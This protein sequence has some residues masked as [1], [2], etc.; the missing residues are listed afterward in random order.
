MKTAG[1]RHLLALALDGLAVALVAG[2]GCT[3]LLLLAG[4]QIL[5]WYWPLVVFA[6]TLAVMILRLRRY[7]LSRYAVAQLL[8]TRL[9]LHDRLST[10]VWFRDRSEGPGEVLQAI[11]TQASSSLQPA[12]VERSFPITFP[13]YGY[14]GVALLAAAAGLFGVRYLVLHTVDLQKPLARL[15]LAF[16][17]PEPKTTQAASR[18]SVVKE[19]LDQQLQELGLPV[20]DPQTPDGSAVQP[21]E[22]TIPGGADQ[23]SPAAGKGSTPQQQPSPDG[24]DTGE[25]SG[26]PTAGEQG[27]AAG[28]NAVDKQTPGKNQ[29]PPKDGAKP[30]QGGNNSNLMN[31]LRDALANMMNKMKMPPQEGQSAENQQDAKQG[32]GQ[33]QGN[34]GKAQAQGKGQQSQQQGEQQGEQEGEQVAGDNSRSGDKSSDKAGGEQSKSGRGRS[35]GDKSIRDA[36][37]LAAMGKLSEILGKRSQQITGEMTVE[38]S[39]GKQQLKTGWTERKA[40][41]GDTGGEANR[42]EI[43]LAYQTYVQRYFEAVR[44]P[45]ATKPAGGTPKTGSD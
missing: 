35:E 20:D 12:D 18:K 34:Q 39:S 37:Q 11:E 40:L 13:R 4:T 36:E 45:A 22:S 17:Q 26:E 29:A 43:P 1:R 42:D 27:E 24:V 14:V 23:N 6:A 8:D 19:R 31:K 7:R 2:A 30:G 21:I 15:D 10:L 3:I 28:E 32:Q 25:K 44:K 16:F 41:H 38:V 33:Q 5:N 9:G